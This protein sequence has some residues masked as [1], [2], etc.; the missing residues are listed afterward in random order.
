MA[1]LIQ[2]PGEKRRFLAGM[3]WR[4]EDRYPS[5]KALLDGARGRDFWVAVRRTKMRSIQSG[6]CE[7]AMDPV[8][9][10]DSRT[11]KPIS[12][13]VY[14]LAGALAEVLE[15]PW[16]GIFDLGNGLYWYIAV[17]EN[18]EI[19][20]DGD[21]IGDFDTVDR[22]RRGHASYGEWSNLLDG[23]IDELAEL[24]RKSRK[25]PLL[26]DVRRKPWV[27]PVLFGAG[28]VAIGSAVMGGLYFYNQH[29]A[30]IEAQKRIAV[31]HR[32]AIERAMDAKKA[33]AN[34]PWRRTPVPSAL[35]SHCLQA[36]S[37]VP[38]SKSGWVLHRVQCVAQ[39][40]PAGAWRE[41]AA[42][43]IGPGAT[44]LHHPQGILA[45]SGKAITEG[46]V[47][48]GKLIVP[49]TAGVASASIAQAQL[50]GIAQLLGIKVRIFPIVSP[51]GKALP[52]QQKATAQKGRAHH[53]WNTFGVMMQC[54]LPVLQE[55]A[56]LLD[57]VPGLRL[58]TVIV[59]GFGFGNGKNNAGIGLSTA[60]IA[61]K[62]YVQ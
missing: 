19:L 62:L 8:T 22:A 17:R 28:A 21:V 42:W 44:T 47:G 29:E 39:P 18:Y 40:S 33:A 38:V 25:P 9:G 26:R 56:G 12:G 50:Y 43:A 45:S 24:V 55:A 4:H 6:F 14:S 32:I 16:L 61:G 34:V 36:L 58:S 10:M 27:T 23:G 30:Q 41:T 60:K 49:A 20:P 1:L 51:A 15:E 59:Q 31:A 37:T 46:I 5:H 35:V 13:K 3:Y 57:T 7:P 11:N 53:P 2:I 54:P 48:Q 52:G